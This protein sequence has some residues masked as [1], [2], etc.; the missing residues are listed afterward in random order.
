[1]TARSRRGLSAWTR[2]LRAESIAALALSL[3]GYRVLARRLRTPVGEIDLV[4][5]RADSLVFVE[6]KARPTLAS[7]LEAVP[8]SA[9]MRL[10]RA[11]ASALA[12]R[13]EWARGTVR[14][15]LVAV[16]PWRW[17]T[18][19]PNAFAPGNLSR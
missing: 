19:V 11:A 7:A 8:P 14:F 5:R 10:S 18:H 1:M 16:V 3:K 4:V 17:P 15:D 13:P 12:A 9:Q 6:V 2:G